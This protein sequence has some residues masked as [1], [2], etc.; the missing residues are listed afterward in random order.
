[1]I[2]DGDTLYDWLAGSD[3]PLAPSGSHWLLHVL[4]SRYLDAGCRHFDFM[5]A[6]TPGVSDFKR[7]FGGSQI[8]YMEMEWYRPSLLRHVNQLRSRLKQ[9]QRGLT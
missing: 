2:R 4:L 3:P 7:S 1:M 6:N 8:A 9:R 5:G